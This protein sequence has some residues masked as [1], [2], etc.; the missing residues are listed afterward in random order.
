MRGLN[1][2]KNILITTMTFI[3]I[4]LL[5]LL[6]IHAYVYWH[7]WT[8]L[9]FTSIWKTVILS[10]MTLSFACLFL[11]LSPAQDKMPMI[12]ARFVYE[13]GTSWL[14]IFLYLFLIYLLIDICIIFH[15]FSRSITIYSVPFSVGI[16]MFIVLLLFCGNVRYN[17][18]Y[19]RELDI[20]TSKFVKK[21]YKL[22]MCSDLHL[23]YNNTKDEFKRW[24]DLI[25]DEKPDI[26]LIAG[27]IID[28]NIRPLEEENIAKVFKS[29]NAPIYAC[30]GNHEYLAGKERSISFYKECGIQLL[31]DSVTTFN[32]LNI[33]GRDDKYNP[34]RQSLHTLTKSLDNTRFTILLDHQP[35]KL[36][37]AASSG[38]DLQLS[39]HTHHGQIWPINWITDI[40]YEC[41]YGE[42]DKGKTKYFIS[43]G[44]GIWGG[45]FRICTTS[46]YLVINIDK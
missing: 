12:I 43:S 7:V 23:G 11:Y 13:L 18:K 9:P 39:G 31:V 42:Y 44:L 38:I 10:A 41:A 6:V 24:V 17:H 45:K 20:K 46:E 16:T 5:L 3:I 19:K 25:N 1:N 26:I 8:M 14:I 32:E 22:L 34:S 15:L 27:D 30:L 29:L 36:E 28:G 2:K 33:I 4:F 21:P 35:Y 40:I 37:E